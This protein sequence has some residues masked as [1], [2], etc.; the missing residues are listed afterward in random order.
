MKIKFLGAAGTVT[1]SSYVLTSDSG[2]SILVDLGMFQGTPDIEQLNYLPYDYNCALLDDAVLTHAHLDHCGRLPILIS[3]GFKGKI[4]MTAPT[5]ELTELSLL[6]SA[7]IAVQ[8]NKK[9]LYDRELAYKT[10]DRFKT[11]EYRQ[12]FQAGDFKITMRDAG[13]ILGSASLEI[14]DL[15]CSS[16][17]RKIVM[18]G[19][20]GNYPESLVKTTE[21]ISDADAVVMES[22]YGDR[23]HPKEDSSQMLQDEINAVEASGGTLLIPTFA[24]ER[25]Q[26]ILHLVMHLKKEGKIKSQTPIVLDSPMA[27]RATEI[28]LEYPELFN[29]HIEEDLS[30][31][32]IFD[33]DGLE[34]TAKRSQ[35]HALYLRQTAQV[36]LAGSGMMSGGRI[37]GHAAQYLGNAKNRL[38]IVGYQG[39]GTLGRKL[40]DGEK[41]VLIDNKLIQVKASV[42]VTHAMSSHADQ[43]QLMD[44]LNH[45]QGVRKVI[46]THG[47]DPSREALATRI[48]AE[49]GISQI[50][51]PQLNQE[52]ML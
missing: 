1:G 8:D 12:P 19:D 34:V 33:I 3:Q 5:A 14:E 36:I 17:I 48:R 7:K 45:I 13:H 31:G 9:I 41:Q 2:R 38:F 28:Y 50:L 25:T 44:W 22:T 35:S 11:V 21:F 18:S 27:D 52:I 6:D 39:E 29:L 46:L 24:L 23:L 26:E 40:M 30:R 47:E 15:R 10:I 42:T 32:G 4:Y 49:F 51:L 16:E 37:V 43:Q 20:I